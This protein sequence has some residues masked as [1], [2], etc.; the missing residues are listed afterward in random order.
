MKVL[1]HDSVLLS[2]PFTALPGNAFERL[3]GQGM[4]TVGI[5]GE[6]DERT[7]K[8]TAHH[9][10]AKSGTFA[11]A[12]E[13]TKDL[14]F[15]SR[16]L[17]G[18]SEGTEVRLEY[19]GGKLRLVLPPNALVAEAPPEAGARVAFNGR[20]KPKTL[21]NA[22]G[23]VESIR[24]GKANV[25]FDAGDRRRLTEATGRDYPESVPA[26]FGILDQLDREQSE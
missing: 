15:I 24:N 26:V 20:V 2:L 23:T 5:V 11:T 19:Q 1:T 14:E 4:A 10:A 17:S 9:A 21:L 13:I 22:R 6:L 18:I 3:D 25:V 16:A 12:R 8:H 7:V